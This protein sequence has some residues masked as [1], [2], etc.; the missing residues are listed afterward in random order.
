MQI[1]FIGLEGM[2]FRL[3]QSIRRKGHEV[4]AYD[5]AEDALLSGEQHNL[6]TVQSLQD[7]AESLETKRVIWMM[8]PHQEAIDHT[9]EDLKHYLSVGDIVIDSSRSFYKDSIR[10][11]KELE[12]LQI[13]YLD[14]GIPG[15]TDPALRNLY[16]IVGGNRF[17]FNHCE[18][19]FKDI[20]APEGYL[21]SGTSGSGHFTK[22]IYD[23]TKEVPQALELL[24]RSELNLNVERIAR[25]FKV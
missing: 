24:R 7:L 20:A 25:L 6:K 4:I 15:N 2:G 8:M 19:L 5:L 9:L 13:N 12:A 18:L 14:C 3:A 10:R 23:N 11:G 17:A 16:L 22:S 1:G 21:Y